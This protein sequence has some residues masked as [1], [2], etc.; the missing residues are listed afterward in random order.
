MEKSVRE[1][2]FFFSVFF[3]HYLRMFLHHFYSLLSLPSFGFPNLSQIHDCL[4]VFAHRHTH[5][6]PAVSI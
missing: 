1:F 2:R 3:P 6:Q 5:T 4:F